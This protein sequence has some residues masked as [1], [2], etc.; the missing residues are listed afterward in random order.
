MKPITSQRHA[1]E[2]MALAAIAFELREVPLS[3]D[4]IG[5]HGITERERSSLTLNLSLAIRLWVR[6]R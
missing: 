2:L 1:G 4:F 3:D 5:L 6:C